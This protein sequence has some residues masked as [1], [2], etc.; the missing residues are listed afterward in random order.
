MRKKQKLLLKAICFLLA[1]SFKS[2]LVNEKAYPPEPEHTDKPIKAQITA[3]K[4]KKY[5]KTIQN[6]SPRSSRTLRN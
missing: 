1:E 4:Y 3:Q 6:D 5:D 2:R